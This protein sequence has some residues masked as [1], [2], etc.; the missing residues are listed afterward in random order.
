MRFDKAKWANSQLQRWRAWPVIFDPLA[1]AGIVFLLLYAQASMYWFFIVL[2]VWVSVRMLAFRRRCINE[3]IWRTETSVLRFRQQASP[4]APASPPALRTPRDADPQ[5]SLTERVRRAVSAV[6]AVA[7]VAYAASLN[8]PG[9]WVVAV[10]YM[11]APMIAIW[12]GDPLGGDMAE[13]FGFEQYDLLVE[14]LG[15][16]VLCLTPLAVHLFKWRLELWSSF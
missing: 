1:W 13:W 11:I 16:L 5:L 7:F 9:L 8:P 4:T 15:W 12:F 3:G 6:L 10:A 14:I 2:V